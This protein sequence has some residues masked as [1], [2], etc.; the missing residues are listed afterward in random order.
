MQL[1]AKHSNFYRFLTA[2]RELAHKQ[3]N[4][5]PVALKKPEILGELRPENFGLGSK[6]QIPLSKFVNYSGVDD[7]TSIED[8]VQIL[9]KI[10]AGTMAA[11]F[12]HLEVS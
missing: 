7:S 9:D 6:D 12:R 11:E 5:D 1:R 2:Y 8:V 10:Y 3:S 4:I